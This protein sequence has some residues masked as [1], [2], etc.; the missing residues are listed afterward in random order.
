MTILKLALLGSLRIAILGSL[1]VAL[2]VYA[3]FLC[4][5]SAADRVTEG[6]GDGGDPASYGAT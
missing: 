3:L 1:K 5:K 6:N 2:L 4:D